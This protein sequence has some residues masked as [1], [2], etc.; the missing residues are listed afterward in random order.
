MIAIATALY[1][2]APSRA[3]I[4]SVCLALATVLAAPV[5]FAAVLAG[6]R[7]LSDRAPRLSTLALALG[8][9]RGTTL[10]SIALAATGAVALFGSVA[11]GG[12]RANLLSGIQNFARSY[13]ADAPVWVGEPAESGQAT[14]QLA[15]DGGAARIRSLPGVASVSAFQGTFMTLGPRRVWVIAR[16]PAARPTC[17][18]PRRSAELAPPP[19]PAAAWPKEA[20]SSSRNRS[21]PNSTPV[22]GRPSR[23]PRR[24]AT[25][26]TGSLR[27]RRNLAWPPG[28]VVM[29]TADFS[30]AWSTTLPERA[31]RL[32]SCGCSRGQDPPRDPLGSWVSQRHRSHL[33]PR[34]PG[35]HR[36]SHWRRSLPARHRL[37][38]PR[39]RSDHGARRGASRP[40]STSGVARSPAFALRAPHLPGCAASCSRKPRSWS[41]PVA[42]RVPSSAST[43]SS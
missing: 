22:W 34:T 20:P 6:A 31:G 13:A 9:V 43:A 37:P 19:L 3:L 30:R 39:P 42:S 28:V 36:H 40:A 11:L 24:P 10:R 23:S 27:S 41:A 12:A 4:A 17:S 21:P 15:G 5:A 7:A 33:R 16:P 32:P 8:G 14:G 2:A 35:R 18:P 1:V 25:A 29:S 26:A 38:A